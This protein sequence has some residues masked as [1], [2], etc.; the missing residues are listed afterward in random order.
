MELTISELGEMVKERM[1]IIDFIEQCNIT[2]ED[3]VDR[4][5]DMLEEH[6]DK[7]IEAV[8]EEN[9]AETGDSNY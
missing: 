2:I 3:L 6:R 9:S 5:P 8:Y 4:F 1:D 7:L